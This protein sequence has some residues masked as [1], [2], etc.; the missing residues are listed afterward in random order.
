MTDVAREVAVPAPPGEV[1]EELI[2]PQRLGEWFG[3]EVEGEVGEGELVR[4]DERR[5]VVER[6]E[7]PRRL[8][9]RWLPTIDEAPSRVE[10]EIDEIPDGSIVRVIE[11]R[12]S[13]AVSP[14][15]EIGFL[16]RV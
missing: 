4:F 15:P 6:V 16:A 1:W 13:P 7:A 14:E 2:D 10:I 8:V 9:F 3:A 11:R 12:I 5:A